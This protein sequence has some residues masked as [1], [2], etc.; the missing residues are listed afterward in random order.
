[1]LGRRVRTRDFGEKEEQTEQ[2]DVDQTLATSRKASLVGKSRDHEGNFGRREG[3]TGVQ[4]SQMSR[5]LV[6]YMVRSTALDAVINRHKPDW[7]D[8]AHPVSVSVS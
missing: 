6:W 8:K 3:R 1:M 7:I 4:M 2:Q 5:C